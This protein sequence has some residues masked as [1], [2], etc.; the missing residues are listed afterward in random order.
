VWNL[1]WAKKGEKLLT[2]DH[3][4]RP[5]VSEMTNTT[6]NANLLDAKTSG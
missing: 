3:V 1:S 6:S 4:L 2:L 5:K